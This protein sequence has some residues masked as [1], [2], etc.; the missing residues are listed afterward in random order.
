[1]L[2]GVIVGVER[3]YKLRIVVSVMYSMMVLKSNES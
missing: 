3:L 2:I 1:M